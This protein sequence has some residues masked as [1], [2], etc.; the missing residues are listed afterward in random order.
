MVLLGGV[1]SVAILMV[2]SVSPVLH[3]YLCI[4]I[5]VATSARYE[6]AFLIASVHQLWYDLH[7]THSQIL[8]LHCFELFCIV[9]HCTA[10]FWYEAVHPI[11]TKNCWRSTAET[12][13]HFE[14]TIVLQMTNCV[15][16]YLCNCVEHTYICPIVLCT[17]QRSNYV[18]LWRCNCLSLW[19]FNWF[20][21]AFHNVYMCAMVKLYCTVYIQLCNCV[22]QYMCNCVALWG[23]GEGNWE[24]V[25]ADVNV[26]N[27][28]P[29]PVQCRPLQ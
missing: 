29:P 12:Q 24:K 6:Q 20:A 26:P 18:T 19:M 23:Q 22:A 28:R 10:K 11:R 27:P 8:Q 4:H 21:I 15:V 2:S 3:P 14:S 1:T 9:L 25:A 7:P 16:Q 5:V 17:L 13:L